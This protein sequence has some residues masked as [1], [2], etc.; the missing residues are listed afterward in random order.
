MIDELSVRQWQEQFRAGAFDAKD[1][2][3]QCT[4]GWCDWFCQD[5]A[6]AGRLKKIA[7]VVMGITDPFILDNY[8]VW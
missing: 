6:L 7:R 5:E 8:Y 4:A 1:I 2:H 3:I